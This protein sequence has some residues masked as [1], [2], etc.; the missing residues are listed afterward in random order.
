M[1]KN[2]IDRL[3][4]YYRYAKTIAG[5]DGV[6]LLHHLLIHLPSNLKTDVPQ[7]LDRYIYKSLSNAYYNKNSTFN[8]LH[9]PLKEVE[10]EYFGGGYDIVQLNKIL[11]E[12][13]IEGHE[14]KVTIFKDSYFGSNEYTVSKQ[15]GMTRYKVKRACDF[16]KQQIRER[17]VK[18]D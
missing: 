5:S 13:E 17:Y 9:Y 6:D 10:P 18:H 8:K 3:D 16:I 14:E 15:K 2:I 1:D 4:K 11:L 12:L 7:Q